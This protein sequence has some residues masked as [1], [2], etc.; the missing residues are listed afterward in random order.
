MRLLGH[1]EA[2]VHLF[3]GGGMDQLSGEFRSLQRIVSERTTPIA[4][5]TGAGLSMPAGMPSWAKL[6]HEL[7]S[8]L[9]RKSEELGEGKNQAL[10]KYRAAEALSDDPWRSFQLIKEG[11]GGPA[12][13]TLIRELIA[14]ARVKALP[15]G[16]ELLAK[17]DPRAVLNLNIDR[18]A[19]RALQDE[20][21]LT[22]FE[23]VDVADYFHVFRSPHRFVANLHGEIERVSSWVFTESELSRLSQQ[24]SYQPFIQACLTQFCCVFIGISP[25]DVA[26]GGHLDRVA[27]IAPSTGPHFW[28]TS[29]DSYELDKWAQRARIIPIRYKVVGDSHDELYRLISLLVSYKSIDPEEVPLSPSGLALSPSL[30]LEA[31]DLLA[32]RSAEEIRVAV[33]ARATELLRPGSQVAYEAFNQFA[34]EYEVPIYRAWHVSDKAPNNKLLGFELHRRVGGGAFGTVYFAT[35]SEGSPV[36]V[37]IL[38]QT[39]RHEDEMLQGFRRGARAM[40]ILTAAEVEG[41]CRYIAASEIPAMVVMEWIEGPTLKDLISSKQLSQDPYPR[42]DIANQLVK[43]IQEAHSLPARVLHRDVRPTNIMLR[44]YWASSEIDVVVLDFDLSWHKDAQELSIVQGAS[45]SGYLAPEQLD[46]GRKVPT[47]SALVDSFGIGMTIFYIFSGRDPFPG[48]SLHATWSETLRRL[49]SDWTRGGWMS[50]GNRIARI[51]QVSTF[52]VQARRWD[53]SQIRGEL[54]RLRSVASAPE[55]VSDADL[56]AEELLAR[57]YRSDYVVNADATSFQ[58][59]SVSGVSMEARG[60]QNSKAVELNIRWTDSGQND[61]RRVKK[62]VEPSMHSAIEMLKSV[63]WKVV[64]QR[65]SPQDLEIKAV[66]ESKLIAIKM[67]SFSA[68]LVRVGEKLIF[69]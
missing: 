69:S 37:K 22:E 68:G 62:W 47:R 59:T 15:E 65:F 31:P 24:P 23:G 21:S 45:S 13:E 30:A 56:L 64:E 26:V 19:T 35:S 40:Q 2:G 58:R 49:A 38:H 36:A 67:E 60:A 44:D 42:L 61:H 51:I 12:Y 41:V 46:A 20:R 39:V 55:E 34:R 8:A 28:F 54:E 33:N 5:W 63:G 17:L 66:V 57:A 25:Y 10:S 3:F 43:I 18:L 32:K 4:V 14:P 11:L 48:E 7:L 16:Y 9:R 6:R 50:L 53:L 1:E 52:S 27:T 29:Y